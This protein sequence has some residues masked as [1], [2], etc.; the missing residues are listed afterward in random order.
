MSVTA[1]GVTLT[2]TILDVHLLAGGHG[3]TVGNRGAALSAQR[4]SSNGARLG[5]QHDHH[6]DDHGAGGQPQTDAFQ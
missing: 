1:L 3:A 6:D 4:A 2:E 5:A